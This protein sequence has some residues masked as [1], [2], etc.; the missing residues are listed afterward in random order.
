[1]EGILVAAG[2]LVESD[3]LPFSPNEGWMDDEELLKHT[4][5]GTNAR[6]KLFG[7]IERSKDLLKGA[8]VK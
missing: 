4:D 7:R 5:R 3:N 6:K 8:E 1:L 2:E